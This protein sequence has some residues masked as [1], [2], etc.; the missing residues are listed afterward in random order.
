MCDKDC[1]CAS[2][3]YVNKCV[4]KLKE[5]TDKLQIENNKLQYQ[6]NKLTA[7]VEYLKKQIRF[8]D[9]QF[10]VIGDK[11]EL[12]VPTDIWENGHIIGYA[13]FNDN[14]PLSINIDSLF[15]ENYDELLNGG[16][17]LYLDGIIIGTFTLKDGES[18]DGTI[19]IAS[20]TAER[21]VFTSTSTKY[22][23]N[24]TITC[25]LER[26]SYR[27]FKGNVTYYLKSGNSEKKFSN[28]GI[29]RTDGIMDFT[30]NTID[31][32]NDQPLYIYQENLSLAFAKSII[33]FKFT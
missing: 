20:S 13:I 12:N 24:T 1:D 6:I 32:Q 27:P 29:Y 28:Y 10:I 17:D 33:N 18:V 31:L 25:I 21:M 19:G 4:C 11:I 2:V 14:C 5:R 9:K 16:T 3:K 30:G 15:N 22:N 7:T 23:T 26:P 8:I